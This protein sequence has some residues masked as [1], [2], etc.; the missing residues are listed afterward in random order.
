MTSE[1]IYVLYTIYHVMGMSGI[2]SIQRPLSITDINGTI[3]FLKLAW[4]LMM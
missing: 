4:R 2:F 3:F 1:F